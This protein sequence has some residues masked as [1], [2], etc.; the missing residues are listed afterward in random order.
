LNDFKNAW[1]DNAGFNPASMSVIVPMFNAERYIAEAIQS[2]F[3]QTHPPAEIIIVDDGSTDGS[4]VIAQSYAP[5]A[6]YLS[7]ANL[8]PA[9][10]RNLGIEC[11]TGDLLAFLDADDLWTPDKLA[12]QV[13]VLKTDPA[14]EAVLG[15]IENFISPELGEDERRSL[16]KA[17]TQTG[18]F[19]IGALLIRRAAFLR[20]GCFDARWRHGEF[21]EWWARALRLNLIYTVLPD[22]V[23]RRRLHTDNLTRRERNRQEYLPMLREH[24]AQHRTVASPPGNPA[25]EET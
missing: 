7:Q 14:R 16:A 1:R 8:G 15:R 12:R 17:A 2:V 10:A 21:I 22:L 23:L 19:H 9:A 13:Q 20:V 4:A 3:D 18:N 25:K 6:R 11:A 24:L 5:R